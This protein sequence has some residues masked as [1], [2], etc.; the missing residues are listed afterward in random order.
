ML[1]AFTMANTVKECRTT[2]DSSSRLLRLLP[3]S[4]PF[5]YNLHVFPVPPSRLLPRFNCDILK[6]RRRCISERINMYSPRS[7]TP[8]SLA[9]LDP[10]ILY[11]RH[12]K[13]RSSAKVVDR[14]R[15]EGR[16]CSYRVLSC[17]RESFISNVVWDQFRDTKITKVSTCVS[18][19]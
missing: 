17:S 15:E 3:L 10:V 8:R 11:N 7:H 9:S 13:L 1:A 19:R 14:H 5:P 18:G 2:H 4:P 12:I 16:C 6:A